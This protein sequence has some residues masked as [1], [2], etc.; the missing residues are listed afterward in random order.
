MTDVRVERGG[1]SAAAPAAD[2]DDGPDDLTGPGLELWVAALRALDRPAGGTAVGP[3]PSFWRWVAF[4]P[5]MRDPD[6]LLCLPRRVLCRVCDL[7]LGETD[8]PV[9]ALFIARRHRREVRRS[10]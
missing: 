4:D 10:A 1:V 6:T 5:P 3:H 8:D 2:V 7:E 9:E